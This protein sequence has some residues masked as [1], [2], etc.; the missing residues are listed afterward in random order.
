MS[1][2][3]TFTATSK[4]RPLPP[5]GSHVARVYQVIDLGTHEAEFEGIKKMRSLVRISFELPNE[6]AVFDEEKGEQPFVVHTGNLTNSMHEKSKLRPIVEGITGA[7]KEDEA[8]S[9]DLS[10]LIKLDCLVNIEHNEYKGNVYAN[11]KSTSPVPKGMTVPALTNPTLVFTLD[12]FEREAFDKLPEFL[13]KKIEE[14]V[15]YKEL[16]KETGAN[17]D[18]PF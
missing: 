14:S 11:I 5:K 12:K 2:K 16:F 4:D 7:L 1:L 15:E 6:K 17:D 10:S 9:F 13:R 3:S 18:I 8:K